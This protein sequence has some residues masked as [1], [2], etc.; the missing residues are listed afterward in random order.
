MKETVLD[1]KA[2]SMQDNL[3]SKR[4]PEMPGENA[5]EEIENGNWKCDLE[6]Y[7]VSR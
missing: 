2:R 1:F 6:R 5:K 7:Q 3:L 4:N